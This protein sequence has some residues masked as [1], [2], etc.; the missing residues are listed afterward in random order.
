MALGIILLLIWLVLLIRF[1]RVMVPAS[2]GV[3]AVALLLAALVALWQWFNQRHT[4]ELDFNF[5][6]AP[7]ECEPGQPLQLV[8]VNQ[9]SRGI[10]NITWQLIGS[11]AGM[12]TNMLD[13][14]GAGANYRYDGPLPAGEEW[15]QCY[16]LPRLR[17][18]YR[19][20]DLNF[21]AEHIR[22]DVN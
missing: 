4:D 18:G 14:G 7:A 1:P 21:R 16:E 10:S 9:S 15:Q 2:A 6:Y 11:P 22:A 20:Q 3:V 5:R 19:A 13:V 12:N 8:L 17:S